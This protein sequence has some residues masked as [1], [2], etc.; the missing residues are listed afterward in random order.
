MSAGSQPNA[1]RP[2]PEPF[3]CEVSRQDS[4]ATVRAIGELDLATVPALDDQLAELR[5]AGIRRLILDLRGLDFIDSTGL[6]LILEY[7][8]LARNDGFSIALIKGPDAV[9][10]IFE[11]TGT[12]AQLPFVDD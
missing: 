7:D 3:R 9:Q 12:T 6:R 1:P 10:R 2:S 4:S 5:D 11:I 8:A